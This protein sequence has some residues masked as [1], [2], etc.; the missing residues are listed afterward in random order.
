[1]QCKFNLFT[2]PLDRT[3]QGF[4]IFKLNVNINSLYKTHLILSVYKQHSWEKKHYMML[5]KYFL[6]KIF[7]LAR[8]FVLRK[9]SFESSSSSNLNN[10]FDDLF[11]HTYTVGSR[12]IDS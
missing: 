2:V 6:N 1:M 8:L 3:Q 10:T 11:H 4:Y 7:N 9:L 12:G 5:N